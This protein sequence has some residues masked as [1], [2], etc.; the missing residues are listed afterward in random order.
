MRDIMRILL[1]MSFIWLLPSAVFSADKK[2]EI[3]LDSFDDSAFDFEDDEMEEDTFK[4]NDSVPGWNKTCFKFNYWFLR[5]VMIPVSSKYKKVVPEQV[6]GKFTNF[7]YNLRGPVRGLNCLLQGKFKNAEQEVGRLVINSTIGVFGLFNPAESK[8]GIVTQNE[9]F[10]QTL[11][12]WGVG[13]GTYL[14][15]PFLGPKTLRDFVVWPVDSMLTL[16]SYV[17][18]NDFW[19]KSSV[20]SLEIVDNTANNIETLKSIEKDALDPYTHVRDAYLQLR[21]GQVKD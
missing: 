17:V 10:G 13:G 1:L 20:N 3:S 7:F 8:F 9:D 15:I 21:E 11:G 14:Q 16:D 18:P 2:S 6:R 5:K 4:A 19:T 12:K